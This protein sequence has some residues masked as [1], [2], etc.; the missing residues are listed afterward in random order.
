MMLYTNY[1]SSTLPKKSIV[2]PNK[3][4]VSFLCEFLGIDVKMEVE[5]VLNNRI[6]GDIR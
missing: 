4:R 3:T 5:G 2:R 1:V 6:K